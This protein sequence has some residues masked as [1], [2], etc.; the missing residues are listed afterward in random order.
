M[1][2]CCIL[3]S[4][5]FNKQF[6]FKIALT[7]QVSCI[8]WRTLLS[9]K[10]WNSFRHP[11]AIWRFSCH[12]ACYFYAPWSYCLTI[13]SFWISDE[14]RY[15]YRNYAERGYDRHRTSREKEDRHRDRRHREKEETRHKSSRR[16]DFSFFNRIRKTC[17]L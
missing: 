6:P 16:F 10:H 7:A 14:E 12:L 1:G 9:F 4:F 11:E 13:S 17:P 15:R 8:T 3:F 5:I 2:H